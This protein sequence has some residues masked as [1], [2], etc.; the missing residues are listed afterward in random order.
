LEVVRAFEK[1]FG[2][3]LTYKIVPR[4]AG[5][6]PVSYADP[7]KAQRDLGWKAERDL[8][9]MCADVWRWQSHNPNGYE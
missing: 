6:L 4:R 9:E 7:T 5:D 2:K 3:P 8:E 1:A